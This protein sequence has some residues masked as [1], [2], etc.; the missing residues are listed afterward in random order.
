VTFRP[1]SFVQREH[2]TS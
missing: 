1:T 2:R